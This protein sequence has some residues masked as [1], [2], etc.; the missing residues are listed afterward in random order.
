[1]RDTAIPQIEDSRYYLAHGDTRP[2][3]APSPAAPGTL[4]HPAADDDGGILVR[5]ATVDGPV[6]VT[7]ETFVRGAEIPSTAATG[8][9][10]RRSP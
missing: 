2:S 9:S 4:L 6:E 7:V 5:T 3:G 10:R 1:M 8:T